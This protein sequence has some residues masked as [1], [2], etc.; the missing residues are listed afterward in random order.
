MFYRLIGARPCIWP[1]NRK[2]P[3]LSGRVIV[4]IGEEFEFNKGEN[5]ANSAARLREELQ[6]LYDNIFVD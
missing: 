2:I 6:K 3:R 1:L 4:N 5:R